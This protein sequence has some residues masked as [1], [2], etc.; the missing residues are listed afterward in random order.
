MSRNTQDDSA[1]DKADLQ[2]SLQRSIEEGM[3]GLNKTHYDADPA[4]NN[5]KLFGLFEMDKGIANMVESLYTS[6]IGEFNNFLSPKTYDTIR[7]YAPKI[8]IGGKPLEGTA[9]NRAAA[10]GALAVNLGVTLLPTIGQVINTV[11][12]HHR[13][14][15][16]TARHLAPVLD[17]IV[18]KHSVSAFNGVGKEQNSVIWAQRQRMS[19]E[20]SANSWRLVWSGLAANGAN[21]LGQQ[22]NFRSAVSGKSIHEV[23]LDKYPERAKEL[24]E[25]YTRKET[26][27]E[28]HR[29]RGEELTAEQQENIRNLVE[30]KVGEKLKQETAGEHQ[31]GRLAFFGANFSL[32]MIVNKIAESNQARYNATRQPFSAY[33]MI[34]CLVEQ[35]ENNPGHGDHFQLP[36]KRGRELPLSKYIEELVKLH[37]REMADLDSNYSELRPSLNEDLHDL[38][39][40]VAQAL[41]EGKLSPLMLVRLVGEGKIVKNHGRGLASPTELGTTLESYIGKSHGINNRDPKDYLSNSSFSL[42][43]LKESLSSLQGDERMDLAAFIPDAVLKEAGFSDKEIKKVQDHRLQDTYK[44]VLMHGVAGM[45]AMKDDELKAAGISSAQI[46][47]VREAAQILE[48][49]GE[50]GLDAIISSPTHPDG[51]D[52]TALADLVVPKTAVGDV[53][54]L[55][56][57]VDTGKKASASADD[58]DIGDMK[59]AREVIDL[60]QKSSKSHG[61]HHA[62]HASHASRAV[63][64]RH[65]HEDGEHYAGMG[66]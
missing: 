16:L 30:S 49:R 61:D 51:V 66:A 13:E 8:K 62:K 18:G 55:S 7:T 23:M 28:I 59:E 11:T 19:R 20:A 31:G 9:L 26:D 1:I 40:P 60:V 14:R 17:E 34:Q 32:P 24:R 50:K 64:R 27:K 4:K 15:A 43:Q 36:G 63:S 3:N 44:G 35:M 65:G 2:A 48:E 38:V 42:V 33:E 47:Q 22:L 29:H 46:K 45:A 54:Y 53:H 39:K 5:K 56:K 57:L 12:D 41:R 58:R 52:S 6:L 25:E 37:Q 21:I 10:G